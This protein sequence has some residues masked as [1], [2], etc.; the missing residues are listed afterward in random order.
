MAGLWFA[1]LWTALRDAPLFAAPLFLLLLRATFLRFVL[2]FVF[3]AIVET[4]F[5]STI[6]FARL[7]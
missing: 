7:G 4:F 2:D 6:S 3:L 1:A 5:V